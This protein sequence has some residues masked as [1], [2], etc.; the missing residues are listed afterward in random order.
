MMFVETDSDKLSPIIPAYNEEGRIESVS[1]DYCNH[2]PNQEIIV[3][4]NGCSDST[5]NT[6]RRL[7][8]EYR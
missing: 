4:G 5:A 2:F 3:V 7:C 8:S 1:L 6:V